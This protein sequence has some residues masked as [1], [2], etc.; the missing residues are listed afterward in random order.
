M[1]IPCAANIHITEAS[2]RY[3]VSRSHVRVQAPFSLGR[4][5]VVEATPDSLEGA[6]KS[7]SPNYEL[8]AERVRT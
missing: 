2:R 4:F 7:L 1:S 8:F 5:F 3:I 6:R